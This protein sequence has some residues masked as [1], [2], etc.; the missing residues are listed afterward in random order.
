MI[1]MKINHFS[2]VLSMNMDCHLFLPTD[3]GDKEDKLK[4]LWLL[5]GGSDDE[6]SWLIHSTAPNLADLCG[7]AIVMATGNDSFCVDMVHGLNYG[8]YLGEELPKILRQM[9]PELSEKREDNMISGLSNGG[10]GCFMVGLSHP[11]NFGYIG[12]FSAGDK[13]D[14]K[15]TPAKEGE[16][17]KRVV[18]F[19]QDDIKE[20]EYSI[21]VL[22][23]KVAEGTG[24]R[25]KIYHACG[26]LDPWLDMNRM[27]RDC[28]I[29]LNDP[30][31]CYEYVEVEG[32]GH[33]WDFWDQEVRRFL[34]Y[35]GVTPIR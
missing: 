2:N 34:S 3:R 19:G 8:T 16:M 4:V 26:L 23:R 10:Y 11:E 12:A 24:L 29:A 35:A 14:S 7:I 1:S 13:A 20:S 22:A 33:E 6:N 5:P 9:F 15:Y 32:K 28:F 21:K 25:P 31:F 18:I 27:V 30:D 17:T